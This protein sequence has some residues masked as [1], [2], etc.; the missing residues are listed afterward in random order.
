[1]FRVYDS[2]DAAVAAQ[3]ADAIHLHSPLINLRDVLDGNAWC[4]T[5]A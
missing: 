5:P 1:M 4:P 3:P 2:G